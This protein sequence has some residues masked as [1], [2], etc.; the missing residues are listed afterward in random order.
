MNIFKQTVISTG[1]VLALANCGGSTNEN[2]VPSHQQIQNIV[3]SVAEKTL[4]EVLDEYMESVVASDGP[5]ISAIVKHNDE[6]IFSKSLGKANKNDDID[7]SEETGFRLASVSKTF[8]ALA[9]MQ[10]WENGSL[11]P[12]DNMG[13]YLPSLS[14]EYQQVTIEQLLTH[15]SGIP[16]FIND[17]SDEE[18]LQLDGMTNDDLIEFY[19]SANELEFTP[20]SRAEYSNTG[21][22]LLSEI[23]EVASG[24]EF[25]EYMYNNIFAPLG[26]NHSYIIDGQFPESIE[27]ALSH[28]TNI[29]V[30]GFDSQTH[31]SSGQVSSAQDIMRFLDGVKSNQLITETTFEEMKKRRIYVSNISHHYGYGWLVLNQAETEIYHSG[32]YDGY[33]TIMYMDLEHD[34]E[35]VILTNGGTDT[36]NAMN[37]MKDLIIEFLAIG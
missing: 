10:L 26:M 7:I 33:Q 35:F 32:G 28:G 1:F 30:L 4:T 15:S 18:L 17:N 31:G 36:G 24:L 25:G 6:I 19:R 34:F 5:G 37:E 9:I 27:D 13:Q 23:V 12:S 22:V 11:Q 20:G 2:G 16:D 14:L 29:D 3:E 8:T 21:Y